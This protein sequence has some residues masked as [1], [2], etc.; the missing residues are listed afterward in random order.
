MLAPSASPPSICPHTP[1]SPAPVSQAWPAPASRAP[2]CLGFVPGCRGPLASPRAALCHL[3]GGVTTA[4]ALQDG[5]STRLPA[6]FPLEPQPGQG[7]AGRLLLS[8]LSLHPRCKLREGRLCFPF[9]TVSQPRALP[10]VQQSLMNCPL[11]HS[12]APPG[13]YTA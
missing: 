7:R 5:P 12:T 9:P 6:L 10:A 3:P 2:L 8:S 13:E 11:S 1:L 4:Q